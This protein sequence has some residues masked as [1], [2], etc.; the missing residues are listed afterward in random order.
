MKPHVALV[1]CGSFNPV[2][3][4]HLKMFDIAK[5]YLISKLPFEYT[6]AGIMSPV[7]DL[8]VYKKEELLKSDHRIN[9]I[10]LSL[11]EAKFDWVCCDDWEANQKEWQRTLQV[12]QYHLTCIKS[13]RDRNDNIQVKL[14]SGADLI[15]SM[16]VPGLWNDE[17]VEAIVRDFGL[18]IIPR[19]KFD[20]A[21]FVDNHPILSKHKQNVIIIDC[22]EDECSSTKVR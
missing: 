7:N 14:L 12:L 6:L 19:F 5:N 4:A 22:Q 10:N 18:I 11:K 15:K 2:T 3:R 13:S 8:Y 1:M 17:D 21:N 20:I 16:S 9:M